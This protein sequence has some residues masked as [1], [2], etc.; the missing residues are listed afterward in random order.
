MPQVYTLPLA[1]PQATIETVGGKGASLARL[2]AA[3]FPVPAGFHVTIAAYNQFVV[4]QA[5]QERILFIASAVVLDQPE[6]F[7]EASKRINS[8]F[9]QTAMPEDVAVAIRRAYVFLGKDPA[10][11]VRSSAT[12]EDLPEASFAGQLET[13]LNIFGAE[14]V[15]DAV[16]KCWASLWTARA[17]SYRLRNGMAHQEVSL[18]VVVQKLVPAD[19]AGVLFTV[20]PVNGARDEVVI[21]AAWG[22]GEAIVGGLVTP[23]HLVLAKNSGHLKEAN[24]ANKTIMTVRTAVG[25]TEQPVSPIRQHRRVLNDAEAAQLAALGCRIEAHYM[26]PMDIEWCRAGRRFYIVQARPITALPPEPAAWNTPGPGRW[27][28][29]SGSIEMI[30]E[31]VSPLFATLILPQFEKAIRTLFTDFGMDDVLNRPLFQVVHGYVYACM[32]LHLRPR[33]LLGILRGLRS[34]LFSTKGWEDELDRYRY[35]VSTQDCPNLMELSAGEIYNR[36]TNL[37]TAGLRYWLKIMGMVAQLYQAEA[38]FTKYYELHVR[39]GSDPDAGV[40][41]R[42]LEMRPLDADRALYT[43]SQMAGEP[44]LDEYLQAYGHQISSFDPLAPTQADDPRPLVAAMEAYRAGKESPDA[45]AQ[46]LAAEREGATAQILS[47]L[48]E[49]PRRTFAACLASAQSAAQLRENALF[50]V[51]LAWVPLRCGLLELGKRLAAGG[52]LGEADDIFWLTDEELRAGVAM[53]DTGQGV[54][55]LAYRVAQRRGQAHVDANLQSPYSLPVGRKPAFWWRYAFPVPELNEQRDAGRLHGMGVSSGRITAVARVIHGIEEAQRLNPGEILVTRTT[56]PAWTPLFTQAAGLVTD[57]GGPLSHGSIVAREYGIPAVMGTGSATQRITDGQTITVDGQKGEV[58]LQA[59]PITSLQG[60]NPAAVEWNDSLAGDYLWTTANYGEAVPDVMTPCTWSLVQ[61][62]LDDADPSA[63]PIR[64]YGNIGGRLYAN[65]SAPASLAAAFGFGPSRFAPLIEDGFGRLPEGVEIPIFRLSRLR[66]LREAAPFL[67]GRFSRMQ[68]NLRR[69]PEFLRSAPMRCESLREKIQAASSPQELAYLWD[70][71]IA[72]YMHEAFHMLEAAANQ[73]GAAILFTRRNLQKLVGEED[74]DTLLTGPAGDW[75]YLASLGP[76]IGLAQLAKGEISRETYAR[77]HGHRSPH[78]IEVSTPR[79]AEDPD[80]IDKQ[81][82]GMREANEN[83][84]ALLARREDARQAAWQRLHERSPRKEAAIRRQID[85]WSAV[86]HEREAVRSECIR[87]FSVLRAFVL[88]AGA[89]TGQ[90]ESIF[91][92]SIDEILALL[93]GDQASLASI[94]ARRAAY[95]RYCALPHYPALIHGQFDP[96]QWAADPRR[97]S[98]LFD[99]RNITHEPAHDGITGFPGAPGIVEGRVRVIPTAEDGNQLLAGE[100]LVTT[101]TN[102][103]WTP[104][105]PR[106]AA[107]V[108][109]VGAPLSHAAIVARELGIPAVV[110]CGNATMRLHTGDRVHVDGGQGTVEIL[111]DG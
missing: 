85:R 106:A 75:G 95:E 6:T 89:L 103:G 81:L 59:Q 1:D 58:L 55:T 14:A 64:Q 30:R 11:A 86:A 15:L 65:L 73:G 66:L 37:V 94:P 84:S 96:F 5:L 82:A 25:T 27:V 31:P 111:Q 2:S 68:G 40:F 108:T 44:S 102:I 39:R 57:L 17:I 51:G 76:L 98:D 107:V 99:A 56:T 69:L 45:R 21:D 8:L 36:V 47:R 32:T 7:D 3:G 49:R 88:R 19:A 80:W 87:V 24:I 9:T 100:I 77:E 92:L 109:D 16:K 41:L 29:G 33:H 101:M 72:P 63:G 90:G 18:A 12:A 61:I 23:D 13:Y 38:R 28:H 104:L 54:E 60:H 74:A 67:I 93:S 48:S 79:P 20:N 83:A 52:V 50:D 91:F 46:R 71:E 34:Q 97:R 43:L 10:V 42:G 110:G 62:L 35:S 78:E 26:M 105:F 53:L 4:E 70:G 22:L